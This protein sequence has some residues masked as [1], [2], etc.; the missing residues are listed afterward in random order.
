[1][2][3]KRNK[4]KVEQEKSER[5]TLRRYLI[6]NE[7]CKLRQ[8]LPTVPLYCVSAFRYRANEYVSYE[9]EVPGRLRLRSLS[10]SDVHNNRSLTTI[11]SR[12]LTTRNVLGRRLTRYFRLSL[13]LL[14]RAGSNCSWMAR[15]RDQSQSGRAAHAV[16]DLRED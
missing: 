6:V 9:N 13:F 5:E 1:M 3:G 16:C 14:S 4:R 8:G 2:R 15:G 12:V 7:P 10:V 11:S